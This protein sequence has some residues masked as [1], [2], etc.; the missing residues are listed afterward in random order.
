MDRNC[1]AKWRETKKQKQNQQ[2][3][4]AGAAGDET[5]LEDKKVD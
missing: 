2:L 5:E 1:I 3:V 4:M